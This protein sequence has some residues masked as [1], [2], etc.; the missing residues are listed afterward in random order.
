MPITRP[1]GT[2]TITNTSKIADELLDELMEGEHLEGYA[3]YPYVIKYKPAIGAAPGAPA[4]KLEVG[5]IQIQI[6]KT[7]TAE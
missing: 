5:T 2:V 4:T 3:H 1:G 6:Q 7:T